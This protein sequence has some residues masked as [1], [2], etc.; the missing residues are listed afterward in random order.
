MARVTVAKSVSA[1]RLGSSVLAIVVAVGVL[2]NA[3]PAPPFPAPVLGA[4]LFKA[5]WAYKHDRAWLE[6]QLAWLKSH[7]FDAIRAF[8]V[9]GDPGHP[10]YWDGREIDWR[11]KD[12]ADV[13]AGTTDLAYDKYGI[14]VQWT[15]FADAQ[16]NIPREADRS[17]LV[18]TFIRMARG[19]E[20]KILAFEVAN[21]FWQNGFDGV[22]GAR[23]L[24]TYSRRLHAKT[25]VPVAA[26]AHSD[27]LCP[28]YE[29][30][31][32]DFAS[33]HFDRTSPSARWTPL[34][35]P[36][37]VARRAGQLAAC[38]LPA[39]ASNNEPLGPGSSLPR[40]LT[41]IHIVMSA[42][43]TYLAGIPIYIFHAGPGVRDDPTHPQ[44]LRPSQ[45]EEIPDAVRFF[46][47][48]ASTKKYI[49]PDVFSWVSMAGTDGSFPF[50]VQGQPV[51][52]FGA[53]SAD[54]FVVAVSGVSGSV[55]LIARREMEVRRLEP[56]TGE[57]LETRK[58]K[59]DERF[60]ITSEAAVL[61]GREVPAR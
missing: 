49:P 2:T 6:S 21:E 61:A 9:V 27:A 58:L 7:R 45:L 42:V 18:D 50:A 36:W 34:L 46:D 26:S 1:Q 32:V 4:S 59:T 16:K 37:R 39:A 3:S 12:Y 17:A 48:L 35:M 13:I 54:R 19:R 60:S 53:R 23:Q 38:E 44:G 52:V 55:H 56:L 20:R 22:E 28:I 25:S 33:I 15:I 14:R 29:A 41:P 24:E 43:N 5:A 57:T 40:P 47:G 31:V 8:G 30:G 51:A 10:D 11:W